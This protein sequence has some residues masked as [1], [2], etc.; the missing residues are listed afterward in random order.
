MHICVAGYAEQSEMQDPSHLGHRMKNVNS[1]FF[2]HLAS[3]LARSQPR[4][5]MLVQTEGDAVKKLR[6]AS[7]T[8]RK[9]MLY[10]LT[11]NR[12]TLTL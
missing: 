3:P 2:F 11:H 10:T 7:R 12:H 9:E 5:G 1:F 8:H 6:N 4:N